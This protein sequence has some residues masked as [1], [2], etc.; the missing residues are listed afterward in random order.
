MHMDNKKLGMFQYFSSLDKPGDLVQNV[1][2][3]ML[4]N[5][6]RFNYQGIKA[7]SLISIP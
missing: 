7:E 5:I 2:H 3:S 6:S 1:L 4:F